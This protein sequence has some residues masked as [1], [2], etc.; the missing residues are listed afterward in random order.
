MHC[1]KC[2]AAVPDGAAFCP[3]CGATTADKS[4]AVPPAEP[5]K[6]S[7]KL[8]GCLGI[9]VGVIILLVVVG[10]LA[11]D[12]PGTADDSAPAASAAET[13]PEDLPLAVTA[14]ELFNAYEN[15]EASAQSY[16]G[17]RKL[18]VS[19][20]VDK[21]ILDF[22]DNPVVLLRTP[23]QFMSAHAA[24]AEDA[25]GE[26]PNFNPGD[27]VKLLCQGVSEVIATPMLKDCR[28]APAGTKSQPVQWRD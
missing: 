6:K 5:K 2:G 22:M 7:N 8:L 17:E 12:Q 13:A 23:N 10:S 20:T 25:Q 14:A 16:F 19:G 4:S 24:L 1:V 18:L 3:N 26:A 28:R 27:Q 15:N 9:G 11:P 21:V